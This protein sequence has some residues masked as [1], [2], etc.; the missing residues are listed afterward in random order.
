MPRGRPP[1]A[2]LTVSDEDRVQLLR[3]TKR[4]KSSNGLARRADIVLRCADGLS[5]AQVA[6]ELRVT[7]NTVCKWRSRYIEQGL[8]GLLDE[9]RSGAP[10]TVS[11][12]AVEKVVT[13]TLEE[14]PRDATH[15]STR[16]MAE[17]SGVSRTTVRRIWSAFGLQPHRVE[18]FKLSN[19]PQF[20][21]KVRDIVGLYLNPPEA[22]LVLCVDEKAQIQA[23]DRTQPILPMAPGLPERRTH[24]YRR[25]GITSLFA[26]FDI[27]TGKVI[28]ET[29]RE[30][31]SVEFK[32][33][34]NRIDKEVPDEL[35]VH[36]VLDNYGT[37]KTP[38]I[39]SWLLRHPRFHVHY[40][41]TYSSWINQVERW[42][43]LLSEKQIRR[44]THRSVPQLEQAIRLFLSIYNENP[45]PFI[46]VKTADQIL[47][48]IRR[49]C[50]RISGPGH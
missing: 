18:N 20:I 2:P 39:K 32:S 45:K 40:T 27:A 8:A 28:G 10:R 37:H 30:H 41:P 21:E 11:D 25:H 7:R 5:S 36:L 14:M 22:A 43:A 3:W 4:T 35:D 49:F 12:E 19:D 31:R 9:P 47:E 48:S 38:L 46:W 26:A 17:R 50:V 29:H 6:A 24:D 1:K 13:T 42:F 44:G 15:W 16:S 23:L 34:L 33:F